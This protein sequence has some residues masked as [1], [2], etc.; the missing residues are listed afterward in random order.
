MNAV[1]AEY[2]AVP[3]ALWVFNQK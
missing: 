1:E 2:S 3:L